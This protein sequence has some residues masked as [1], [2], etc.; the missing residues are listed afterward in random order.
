MADEA[1]LPALAGQRSSYAPAFG[2]VVRLAG[3]GGRGDVS[4]APAN[5]LGS[6]VGR[7]PV[8]TRRDSWVPGRMGGQS[9]RSAVHDGR[10]ADSAVL[11]A[12]SVLLADRRLVLFRS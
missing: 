8:C 7:S 2:A 10:S 12:A 1:R 11:P 9:Q 3:S 5:T 6:G 4:P